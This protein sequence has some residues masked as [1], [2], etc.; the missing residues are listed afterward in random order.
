[1]VVT[2]KRYEFTVVIATLALVMYTLALSAVNEVLSPV[3]T[4]KTISNVGSVKAVGVGVYWDQNCTNVVSA[5]DWGMLEP[6]SSKNV[7]VYIR[8]EGNS[9][10]SLSMATSNWN[11]SNAS[12]YITLGW[13]YTGQIVDPESVIEVTLILA[14]SSSITG[15]TSFSFDIV[16]VG[17]G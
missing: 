10:V 5:I 4:D 2:L 6:G 14:V 12:D 3:Q 9:V 17:S 13:D 1:M 15:V 11:P 16:I 7:T 8:N